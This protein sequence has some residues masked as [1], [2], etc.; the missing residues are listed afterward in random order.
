MVEKA[1]EDNPDAKC[2]VFL[3]S[4]GLANGKLE[5]NDI[6]YAVSQTETPV[7]T[8][9]YTDE[10]DMNSLAELSSICEAASIKA[11]SDD[12]MYKIKSLFNSQL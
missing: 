8:I 11:D 6:K 2:M 10:A 4:D 7:Y 3:L 12:I 9:G 1:K 5:L